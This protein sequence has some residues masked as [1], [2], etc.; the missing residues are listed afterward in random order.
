MFQ[1]LYGAIGSS[2]K[3]LQK[4]IFYCFNSYMVRLEGAKIL[5]Y[6]KSINVS[7][8]IWCDWK[9]PGSI[10]SSLISQFQFLYGA[11]GRNPPC[12]PSF[13]NL[14]FNSYMVRLEVA[15][16]SSMATPL[17]VSIPIW[18][19]WKLNDSV[20]SY[21]CL[22]VSIPIWCDWKLSFRPTNM[23][24]NER[25]NSYM[26]RLE[27][28]PGCRHIPIWLVSIPIWCDWKYTGS[29][30]SCIDL[31][32][33]IPIWCDWKKEKRLVSFWRLSFN[34][35]MVRLEGTS[36]L[37]PKCY[38]LVSI[39]IWC[40]WKMASAILVKR[41]VT[42][43]FLYGAIG[44]TLLHGPSWLPSRFNSYMVRLEEPKR[45]PVEWH[46]PVSIPIWCDWKP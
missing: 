7:I 30:S 24:V 11:I 28:S 18:C 13:D 16:Q 3:S 22:F 34:S 9:P 41:P 2:L 38:I 4:A 20:L 36:L 1:F 8:P 40:D 5:P 37:S 29:D 35:Y 32:V 39:P 21:F 10:L 31:L 23:E 26:V 17:H 25:F 12:V 19:D 14:R 33:S 46:N 44:S 15:L 43:Q 45:T 42:F 27:D 6:V